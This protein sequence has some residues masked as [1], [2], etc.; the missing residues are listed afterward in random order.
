VGI[1][2]RQDAYGGDN[3]PRLAVVPSIWSVREMWSGDNYQLALAYFKPAGRWTA[4]KFCTHLSAANALRQG[5]RR[6][7]I[8]RGN[9]FNDCNS[10][11]ARAGRGRL[12][13]TRRIIEWDC[14]NCAGISE[15]LNHATIETPDVNIKYVRSG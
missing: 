7:G 4:G 15:R 3:A 1:G 6:H 9:D 14:K 10:M 8:R 13:A 2:A 12:F 11:F 5:S